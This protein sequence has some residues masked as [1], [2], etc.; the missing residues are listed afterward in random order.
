MKR[1]II[2]AWENKRKKGGGE[3]QMGKRDLEGG[4][5]TF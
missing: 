4:K 1:D 2:K 3:E 5:V